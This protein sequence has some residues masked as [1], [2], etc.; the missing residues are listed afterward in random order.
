MR[1]LKEILRES[2]SPRAAALRAW[3][4][5]HDERNCKATAVGGRCHCTCP[6]HRCIDIYEPEA[7]EV[8]C[9]T[10]RDERVVRL[11]GLSRDDPRFG[12]AQP[13]P[14]CTTPEEQYEATVQRNSPALAMLEEANLTSVYPPDRQAMLQE[15]LTDFAPPTLTLYGDAGTGKSYAAIAVGREAAQRMRVEFTTAVGLLDEIRACY[16]PQAQTEVEDV[17]RRLRSVGLLII[18]DLGAHRDSGHTEEK[19]LQIVNERQA[20][21]LPT[22]VTTNLTEEEMS[23]DRL[24]SRL[25]GQA[26]ALVISY[27]G[28]DR[29]RQ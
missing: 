8:R 9:W 6:D 21:H 28:T 27:G 19:L 13:C 1:S 16:A 22:I 23:Q 29:R 24:R 3:E 17:L 14:A 26:K 10:C 4:Q 5:S 15:W 18:D 2:D 7:G 11:N 25:F 20:R 12:R